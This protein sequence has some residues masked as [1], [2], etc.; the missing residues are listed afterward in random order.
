MELRDKVTE[1]VSG[2]NPLR[3]R[4]ILI[5]AAL[6]GLAVVGILVLLLF[7]FRVL[8]PGR[9][10]NAALAQ[11]TSTNTPSALTTGTPTAVPTAAGPGPTTAPGIIPTITP[12]AG[13]TPAAGTTPTSTVAAPAANA[14]SNPLAGLY[15][16]R[17]RVNPNPR[18]NELIYFF[19]TLTNT[20]GK[21]QFHR[22]CAELYRPGD[23]NS[24]GITSCP[25]QTIPPGTGEVMTGPWNL[26]GI[27]ACVALR[28]RPV[29]RDEGET[30]IALHQPSGADL[31]LDLQVCP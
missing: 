30:R 25:P 28:A 27:H 13:A 10:S 31:W 9:G 8:P 26:T 11:A 3:N 6:A 1:V 19:V 12:P 24:L 21:P 4:L 18:K 23:I 20:T 16:T 7:I 14:P 15:V 2:S 22:V 17:I 29:V 5:I